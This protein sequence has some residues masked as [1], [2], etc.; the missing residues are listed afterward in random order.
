M[1]AGAL[2]MDEAN[3]TTVVSIRSLPLIFMFGY[4]AASL[5]RAKLLIH[6]VSMKYLF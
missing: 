4:I 1:L 3:R 5:A 6:N 2:L